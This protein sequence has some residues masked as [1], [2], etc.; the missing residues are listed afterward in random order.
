[1][2]LDSKT[3]RRVASFTNYRVSPLNHLSIPDVTETSP[4]QYGPLRQAR[5]TVLQSVAY[6]SAR[7][8]EFLGDGV[9][10]ANVLLKFVSGDMSQTAGYVNSHE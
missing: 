2:K 1:L 9:D 8:S 7:L 6:F 5:I 3:S 4:V 10:K